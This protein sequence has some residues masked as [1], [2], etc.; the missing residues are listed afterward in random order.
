MA[1]RSTGAIQL[2]VAA[3]VNTLAQMRAL[4]CNSKL[5]IDLV[6]VQNARELLFVAQI[7]QQLFV[8][9]NDAN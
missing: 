7:K 3:Q 5:E 1:T 2:E 9:A 8:A 4:W 6:D